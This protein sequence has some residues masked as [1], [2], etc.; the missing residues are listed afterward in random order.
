MRD[1]LPETLR[2]AIVTGGQTESQRDAVRF[3]LETWPVPVLAVGGGCDLLNLASGGKQRP[4]GRLASGMTTVRTDDRSVL[5]AGIPGPLTAWMRRTGVVDQVAPDMTAVAWD[6]DGHVVGIES[7]DHRRFGIRFAPHLGASEG[8]RLIL[9]R[10]VREVCGCSSDWRL[11]EQL[12]VLVSAI[13]EQVGDRP[14][15]SLL[16]G[17]LYSTVLTALLR[18][19]LP[20]R[21]VRTVHVDT[22]LMR[23]GE[24]ERVLAL[25]QTLDI[26]QI[27]VVDARREV[28]ADLA[29]TNDWRAREA[30]VIRHLQTIPRRPE[31]GEIALQAF[32]R[33]PMALG[34]GRDT[35]WPG[36]GAPL[37]GNR[38]GDAVLAPIQGYF[39]DEVRQLARLLGV[40]GE[41]VSWPAFP[42]AGLAGRCDGPVTAHRLEI[43]RQADAWLMAELDR[44]GLFPDLVHAA[45]RLT[46]DGA[47]GDALFVQATRSDDGFTGRAEALPADLWEILAARVRDAWPGVRR[48]WYE[49]VPVFPIPADGG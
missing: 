33:G 44:R 42:V 4:M 2:G 41:S 13:Q 17:G 26:R 45:V 28:L 19:A 9:R 21:Q 39:R 31:V 35:G 36:K 22:G 32:G 24:S 12:P 11:P 7:A 18:R 10:F 43:L 29:A 46:G 27:E 34:V 40:V 20:E 3:V 30:C 8:G 1:R 37:S 25:A 48:V 47:G 6:V 16:S 15:V 23:L 5:L 49:T 14:V 38:S